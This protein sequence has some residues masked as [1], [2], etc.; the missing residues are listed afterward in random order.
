MQYV[1]CLFYQLDGKKLSSYVQ[2]W[3][4]LEINDESDVC[5]SHV[6]KIISLN[7]KNEDWLKFSEIISSAGIKGV[8]NYYDSLNFRKNV[9]WMP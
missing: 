5:L 7:E 9:C 8:E 6:A 4:A 1:C 2:D 3:E